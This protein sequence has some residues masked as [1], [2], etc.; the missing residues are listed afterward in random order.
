MDFSKIDGFE[1]TPRRLSCATMRLRAP[2]VT[3]ERP[4]WSSQMLTPASVSAFN[5]GFTS[6]RVLNAF[7]FSSLCAVQRPARGLRDRLTGDP[8]VLIERTRRSGGAEAL[9]ADGLPQVPDPLMP[10]EGGG[11]LD[12]DAS[13]DVRRQHAV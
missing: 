12:G 7:P 2:L 8:K 6:A 9:H 10:P 1:V 4:S 5:F 11:G 13:A 3:S